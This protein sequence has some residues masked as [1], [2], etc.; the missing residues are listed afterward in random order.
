MLEQREETR[1]KRD[2]P[3]IIGDRGI[4]TLNTSTTTLCFH[5]EGTTQARVRLR[6]ENMAS[7][8]KEVGLKEK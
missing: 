3:I 6:K 4:P 1:S 7:C 5:R 2:G 8:H